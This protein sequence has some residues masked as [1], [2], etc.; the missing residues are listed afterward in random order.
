MKVEPQKWGESTRFFARRQIKV[1]GKSASLE[2]DGRE[3]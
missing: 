3:P 1:D 2:M